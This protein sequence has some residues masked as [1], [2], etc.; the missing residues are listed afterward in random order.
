MTA[1]WWRLLV[2]VFLSLRKTTV[3]FRELKLLSIKTLHSTFGWVSWSWP[4]HRVDRSRLCSFVNYNNLIKKKINMWMLPAEEYIKQDQFAPG[5]MFPKVEAVIGPS[6]TVVQRVKQ[7]LPLENLSFD[8]Q[9]DWNHF[10]TII[11][12]KRFALKKHWYFSCQYDKY[13]DNKH[14]LDIYSRRELGLH[15]LDF[16]GENNEWRNKKGL[17]CLLPIPCWIII[18]AVMAA[19]TSYYSSCQ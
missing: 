15:L 14:F 18:I 6:L 8:W 3:I 5:S 19:L 16:R 12:F 7:L 1:K 13:C 9:K 11:S 4:L 17:G 10:W 2:A